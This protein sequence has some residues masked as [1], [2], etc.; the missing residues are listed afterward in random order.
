MDYI[1]YLKDSESRLDRKRRFYESKYIELLADHGPVFDVGCGTGN[2]LARA[3]GSVRCY[4]LDLLRGNA[5]RCQERGIVAAVG[6]IVS[7][8]VRDGGLGGLFASH[9]LEHLGR[10]E[11]LT[12]ATEI[13][14]VLRPGGKAVIVVPY[15]R[16]LWEFYADPT[17]VSPMT[18]KRLRMLF[19]RFARVELVNY[20]IP[21]LKWLLTVRYNQ[22]PLYELLLRFVPLRGRTALI[23]VC[24]K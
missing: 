7:L 13:E 16:D 14:R 21:G 1:H 2:F 6:S 24:T 12:A 17:H 20:C 11:L 19:N 23:A 3:R 4:G 8:P 5:V 22:F 10:D 15:P 18:P 9:V